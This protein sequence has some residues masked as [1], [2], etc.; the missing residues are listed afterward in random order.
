MN[1]YTHLFGEQMNGRK[2]VNPNIIKQ[3]P[4]LNESHGRMLEC[5]FT[6]EEIKRAI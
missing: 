1:F 6:G 3:G 5:T 4:S 2:K